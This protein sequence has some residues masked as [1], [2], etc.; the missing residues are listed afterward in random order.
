MSLG[1]LGMPI[2]WFVGDFRNV[3]FNEIIGFT[4]VSVCFVAVAVSWYQIR[5]D[6]QNQPR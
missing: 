3:G 1:H 4:G 5:R 2:L 6:A